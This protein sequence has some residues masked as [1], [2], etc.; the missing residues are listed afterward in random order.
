MGDGGLSVGSSA[1][2]YYNRKKYKSNKLKN[3]YLGPDFNNQEILK[4]IN[5]NKLNYFKPK[6]PQK[7]IHSHFYGKLQGPSST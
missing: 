4:A 3:V 2:S 6:Y 5:K 1:L 7:F